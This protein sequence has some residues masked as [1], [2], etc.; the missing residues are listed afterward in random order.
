MYKL[1]FFVATLKKDKKKYIWINLKTKYFLPGLCHSKISSTQGHIFEIYPLTVPKKLLRIISK[2]F[3]STL[4]KRKKNNNTQ[5][6][7]NNSTQY[8]WQIKRKQHLNIYTS[9]KAKQF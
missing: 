6:Q 7:Q 3:S 1:P 8:L 2:Q 4:R 9:P 5:Q